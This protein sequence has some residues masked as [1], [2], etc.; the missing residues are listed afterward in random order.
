[1]IIL[2]TLL[3]TVT[4]CGLAL[5]TL[6][7]SETHKSLPSVTYPSGFGVSQR[8]TDL[9][10]D[11]TLFPDREMPEPLPSALARHGY[12]GPS[13]SDLALQTE[14]LPQVGATIGVSFDGIAKTGWIPPDNNLAVGP[15]HIGTIV[16]TSVAVYSKTGTLL[17]GPTNIPTIFAAIGGLCGNDYVVDPIMLYDR[18][19]DRWVIAGIGLDYVSSYGECVAVSTTNDPTGAYSLYFYSYGTTLPDYDKLS[20]WATASNSAYLVTYNLNG[21]Q[22]D[23]CGFDR[24]KMLAGNSSAAQLCQTAPGNES[25]YLPSDMDGPTVPPD[26]TPG[27]FLTWQ[28]NNPGQL[29]LRKLTLNFATGKSSL[30][31]PTTIS[32]AN[33][34]LSCGSGFGNCVPQ[35]GTSQKLDTSAIV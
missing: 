1:M 27:L 30:S 35:P 11:L 10:V 16:N 13:Q 20:T 26:G 18:P 15:N 8:L 9:P 17:S 7:F 12:R 33:D 14:T 24:A 31:S 4:V 29:Y 19:A 6:A 2:K 34:N 21:G 23:I 5:T 25:S 3:R 28:N 22:A 32:V